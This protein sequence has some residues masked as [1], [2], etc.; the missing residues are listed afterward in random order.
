M[1]FFKKLLDLII[2]CFLATSTLIL[3]VLLYI[4]WIWPDAD[5][6]Q[7][8]MTAKDLTFRVIVAN[9]TIW[10]YLLAFLFFIIIFP[11]CYLFLNIWKR[12][13]ISLLFCFIIVYISGYIHYTIYTN[14]DSTLYEDH[15]VSIDEI[16]IKF[17]EKKRNLILIYLES[18][19]SNFALAKHYQKN[20][21][22]N[23]SK[24]Q[25]EG[26][27]SKNH[28]SLTGSDYSIASIVASQC[29]IPLRFIQDRDIW[30]SR[31]FL[32]QAV[33]FVE[34]LKREG[35]QTTIIKAADI[36]FTNADLFSLSHGYNEAMGVDEILATIPQEEH[37]SHMG[38]FEGVKDKTLLDFAKK[39]LESFDKDKPF[40]LTLFSLDTHTPGYFSDNTCSHEFND[41]RDIFMCSDKTIYEFISWLKESPY[42]EN[43]TVVVLGDHLLPSRI[44]TIGRPKRGIYNVFLNL[45]DN[46]KIDK[47]KDFSTYDLAPTILE[48]LN[49]K[50]S[51]RGFG[52]GRSMFNSADTLVAKLGKNNFKILL[53]KKSEIYNSFTKPLDKR[54]DKFSPYKLGTHLNND[55]LTAYSDSYDNSLGAYYFDR[56][57]FKLDDIASDNY[58]VDLK[59]ISIASNRIY[60]LDIFANEEKIYSF[61]NN[62]KH[63]S[64]YILTFEIPKRL[65]KD[66]K[67]N[68]K[69]KSNNNTVTPVQMGINPLDLVIYEKK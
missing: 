53:K 36:K 25:Q 50:M 28:H 18:F 35:Y 65:I 37:A 42:W 64:P 44:K 23:L 11:I 38:T 52:L 41:L 43:T 68:L 46:L 2:L 15:Y 8:S 9:T 60:K 56:F 62:G 1:C 54:S 29:G 3:S 6:E 47:N 48:S 31:Y 67:L 27:Y 59:F 24:L 30:S 40:M 10:D 33:C 4:K 61:S 32:P 22:P 14:S 7:I 39:K 20:L 34:L 12:F 16:D 63:I 19:E 45:P 21:I 17:P 66:G 5:F 13:I 51:P 26:E 57:S 58:K 49:V 55:S 69:L